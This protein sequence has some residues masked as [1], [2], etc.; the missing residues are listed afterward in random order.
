MVLDSLLSNGHSLHHVFPRIPANWPEELEVRE[1]PAGSPNP[2]Q[3][4]ARDP[5]TVRLISN[6]G[7]NRAIRSTKPFPDLPKR[8]DGL[9]DGSMWC[10]LT[11]LFRC[12][13]RLPLATMP[14][15]PEV[16]GFPRPLAQI[17]EADVASEPFSMP[18][19]RED[20]TMDLAPRYVA[21]YEVRAPLKTIIYAFHP[22]SDRFHRES[23]QIEREVSG[24]LERQRRN[25]R[26]GGF[27][28]P[29]NDLFSI[30]ETDNDLFSPF[31]TWWQVTICECEGLE[32]EYSGCVAVGLGLQ[33]FPLEGFMPGWDSTSFAYHS[34]DGGIFHG[35]G[36]KVCRRWKMG[37]SGVGGLESCDDVG[38]LGRKESHE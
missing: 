38:T 21:Y 31:L 2:F 13:A 34:D 30:L 27:I 6:H 22:F 19:R 15:L 26:W 36:I 32:E 9:D 35:T 33:E 18:W 1:R 20:E 24:G 3:L 17:E 11:R 7:Q 37:R 28:E 25:L 23:G 14:A 12:K 4:A 16:M 10:R 8:H 5:H 29:D